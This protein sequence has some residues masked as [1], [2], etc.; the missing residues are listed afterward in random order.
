[1]IS[2]RLVVFNKP[3]FCNRRR[4]HGCCSAAILLIRFPFDVVVVVVS[5][6]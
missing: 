3:H 4:G 2:C 1:M 5:A 6:S